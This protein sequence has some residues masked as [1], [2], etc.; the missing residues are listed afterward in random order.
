MRW[1]RGWADGVYW[2]MT[3]AVDYAQSVDQSRVDIDHVARLGALPK[4]KPRQG[5]QT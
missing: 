4:P 2:P 5:L 3:L 1:L